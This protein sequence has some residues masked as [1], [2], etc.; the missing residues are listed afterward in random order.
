MAVRGFDPKEEGKSYGAV[1]FFGI[2]ALVVVSLWIFFDDNFSRRPW[3]KYQAD[4]NRLD[5][6]KAKDAYDAEQK[7]LD[8]NPEYVALIKKLGAAESS[9][10]HGDLANKL[11]QL[12]IEETERD[13]RFFELDQDVKFIKSELE[14][15]WYEHDHA[16]QLGKNTTPYKNRIDELDKQ[17]AKIEPDLEQARQKRNDIKVEIKKLKSGVTKL[18]DQLAKLTAARDNWARI[19]K[20]ATISLGPITVSKI[21]NIKQVVL[22]EFDRNN[23]DEPVARVDR[24]QSCHSG[25]NRS[26]FEDQPNPFKTH[27]RRKVLLGDSA[28][29][30][31]KFGCTACHNGQ[32]AAV[33]SVEQAHLG[34][35]YGVLGKR[36]WQHPLLEG[37]MVQASCTTC[38]LDVQSLEDAKV[39]A[40]GQRLFEQVGCTGCH[41][42]EG[43]ENIPKVGPSLRRVAGKVDPSW[44]VRWIKNP[45]EFRARTRMPN[46]M[47]NDEQATDIAA[48]IWSSSKTEGDKWLKEHPLPSSYRGADPSLISRGKELVN[49]IGCKG[50]HGIAEGEFSTVLGS[51]KDV[52]PN[53][54]DIAEK[55]GPQWTYHW[56]KNPRAFSPETRM[57]SLRLS[58]DEAVAITGYL[59]TLGRKGRVLAGIE[60]RLTEPKSV[61]RGESLVRKYGCAGCHDIPGMEKESRIGVELTTFGSK[62]LEELFFGNTRDI[63]HTWDDWTFN[64]LKTPRV[65]ATERVE[66]LMPQFNLSD[67]DIKALRILLAG[68]REGKVPPDYKADHSE[69]MV[70]VVEGRRL[71]HQYNCIGCHVIENKGGFV[72]KY[73][74]EDK[75][76]LAPPTLN[77]EGDK[78][79]PNWLY[80]FLQQPV[81]LRPWLQ[82]R[83]PTFGLSDQEVNLLVDY[84]TGLSKVQIPY[85]FFNKDKIPAGYLQA[86]R[87]MF[88]NDYFACLSCHQQGD[89]KPEG[90]PEGWAPDLTLA[91]N[92][93]NPHWIVRWLQDPQKVEPG[94]KMP[95]FYP[96][97]PDDILGGKDDKQIEALKDYIMTLGE[98]GSRP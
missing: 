66:Q 86:A 37:D 32:G 13:V 22:P 60:Q 10:S 77:G 49:A 20:N 7:K 3:K 97:G 56:I 65:Y 14:E 40:R 68:F 6:S 88:S 35:S 55:V 28:H 43:Y 8:T 18:Q 48:Y 67:E 87:T 19:M 12:E 71:M 29:P 25:I 27:P 11:Q 2:C 1:F 75:V 38:H 82:I 57:P 91:K 76:T 9:L 46:F 33:N 74:P 41:L 54:K 15:A 47:F 95:S 70:N 85:V 90:P 79:Q 78:V 30:T 36:F 44:M 92:R 17:Q 21:P 98:N 31:E 52:A 53:L 73:Y 64:K 26:G 83:M 59:M 42:V 93:L 80:G 62:T 58:D 94:T 23:F 72:R 4:F 34:K 50:C 61:K 45:H 24:C 89:R 39:V 69:R 5:Y 63:P 96:G 81:P 16:I 84:F 51:D